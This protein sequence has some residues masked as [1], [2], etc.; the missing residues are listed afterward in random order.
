MIMDWQ[1]MVGFS[2]VFWATYHFFGAM[3][4]YRQERELTRMLRQIGDIN[5]KLDEHERIKR[6]K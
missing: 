2:A 1:F 4:N 6:I 5:T 3:K